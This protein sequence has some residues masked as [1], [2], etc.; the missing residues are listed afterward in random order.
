LERSSCYRMK[1]REHSLFF[2]KGEK[3]KSLKCKVM[4]EVSEIVYFVF[5]C[6]SF[7]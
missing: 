4:I 1:C 5:K 6:L 2:L 7:S 3:K